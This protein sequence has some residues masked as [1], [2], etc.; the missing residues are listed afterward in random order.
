[1]LKGPF[2]ASLRPKALIGPIF[3]VAAC[4]IWPCRALSSPSSPPA[5]LPNG[6][7]S[8]VGTREI[9]P[10]DFGPSNDDKVVVLQPL[11]RPIGLQDPPQP[12]QNSGIDSR[13]WRRRRE[14]FVNYDKHLDKR[15]AL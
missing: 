13:S 2:G 4:C 9:I 3:P 14:D 7:R 6:T 11:G 5:P 12:G 10:E 8:P 1:M 15:R